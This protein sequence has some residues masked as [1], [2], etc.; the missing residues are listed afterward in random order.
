MTPLLV[1]ASAQLNSYYKGNHWHGNITTPLTVV[2][3]YGSSLLSSPWQARLIIL[4]L[5]SQTVSPHFKRVFWHYRLV[6]NALL[7]I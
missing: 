2:T 5:D 7:M 6:P 4:Y 3:P 1:G